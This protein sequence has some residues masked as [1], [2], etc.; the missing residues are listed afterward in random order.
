MLLQAL[1]I[2]LVA[3]CWPARA[4]NAAP[5]EMTLWS[6]GDPNGGWN[7]NQKKTWHATTRWE[8]PGD[9][10][11]LAALT[12]AEGHWKWLDSTQTGAR[13]NGLLVVR[14]S[15]PEAGNN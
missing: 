5:R 7:E 10:S 1:A 13:S 4:I 15:P 12:L 3:L 11:Y 6:D 9:P 8:G 14:S 2:A